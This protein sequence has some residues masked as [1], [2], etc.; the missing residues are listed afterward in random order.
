MGGENDRKTRGQKG[1]GA[2]S[3]HGL[4]GKREETEMVDGYSPTGSCYLAPSLPSP[5]KPVTG[6]KE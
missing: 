1:S 4:M 6:S 3:I 5:P 2:G